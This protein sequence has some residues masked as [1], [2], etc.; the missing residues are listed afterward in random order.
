MQN[1]NQ[2]EIA[3]KIPIICRKNQRKT[4]SVLLVAVTK[5]I[6]I[7]KMR[8]AYSNGLHHFAESYAQEAQIK[9]NKF[10]NQQHIVWHFIGPIQSNKTRFIS[11]NFSWV[12]SVD[13][14]KIAERLNNQ[15]PP[16]KTPL[17]ICIEV[18]LD[19]E[20]SK[21]GVHIDEINDFINEIK[22]YKNLQI[23]GLMAIPRATLSHDEKRQRFRSLKHLLND[24]NQHCCLKMDTLSM[25]MSSDYELAIEE[26][27]TIIRLGTALFGNRTKDS[28]S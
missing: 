10:E 8:E 11:Q 13:R 2:I 24:A 4:D 16:I 7:D 22:Q 12:H 27:A 28:L 9:M 26:G 19:Q 23:R 1:C 17:K 14:K 15:R 3:E 20:P 5:K 25:G 18:N 6:G 21:Q